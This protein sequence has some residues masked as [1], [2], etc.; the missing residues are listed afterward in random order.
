MYSVLVTSE[1]KLIVNI[2]NSVSMCTWLYIQTILYWIE[3]RHGQITIH[4][5]ELQVTFI[6]LRFFY[7]W[8]RVV[9]FFFAFHSDFKI[10]VVWYIIFHRHFFKD[11]NTCIDNLY[12]TTCTDSLNTNTQVVKHYNLK[13]VCVCVGG[14]V[15]PIPISLFGHISAYVTSFPE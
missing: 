7:S 14:G 4:T 15:T 11:S 8:L 13:F 10:R 1:N 6:F 9:Y 12:S 3:Q 5:A 2:C